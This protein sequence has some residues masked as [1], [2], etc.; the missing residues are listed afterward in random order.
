MGNLHITFKQ[1]ENCYFNVVALVPYNWTWSLR[2]LSVSWESERKA[3]LP[4]HSASHEILSG[5]VRSQS[6]FGSDVKKQV[7]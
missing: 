3:A 6:G 4:N 7:T 5:W 2:P 1:Q